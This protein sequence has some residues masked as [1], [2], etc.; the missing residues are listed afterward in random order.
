MRFLEG[1]LRSVKAQYFDPDIVMEYFERF[2]TIRKTIKEQ[3]GVTFADLVDRELPQSS[4]TT[5]FEGR[6]YIKRKYLDQLFDD[7]RYAVDLLEIVDEVSMSTPKTKAT[8]AS[9]GN[10]I[11]ISHASKDKSLVKLFV[12]Q[13]LRLGLEVKTD[14]IFCTSLEGMDIKNGTDFR[15]QIQGALQS[16]KVIILIITPNYKASEVCQNEMGAA[17]ASGKK[18][19]PL[20]VEPIN[21]KSVGVLMEPLQIPRISDATALSKLKDDITQELGI[22]STK[23]DLW[24]TAKAGFLSE[25]AVKLAD[26]KFPKSLSEKEIE[27]IMLESQKLGEQAALAAKKISDL[28]TKYEALSKEKGATATEKIDEKFDDREPLEKFKVL[29]KE[30]KEALS[31]FA[32]VVQAIIV[33]DHFGAL[34]DPPLDENSVELDSSSRKK[35][36]RYDEGHFNVNDENRDVKALRSAISKLQKFIEQETNDQ[37]PDLYEKDYESPLEPDNQEF[38]E[39]HFGLTVPE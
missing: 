18:V 17:W 21:Y 15:N 16:A 36:I 25:L 37:F 10:E 19:I 9:V 13:I 4:G 30:V 6:G 29:T 7:C 28:Q 24:D 33:C 32:R 14:H 22:T 39:E 27:Q 31:P 35:Q 1:P 26:I 11:F 3:H 20:I 5:D 34:Y 2:A 23:T 38:W 12:E 8:Q